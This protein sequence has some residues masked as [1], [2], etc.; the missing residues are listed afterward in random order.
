MMAAYIK[1]LDHNHL[2]MDGF[3][4]SELRAASLDIPEVDIVT[5]HHYPGSHKSFSELITENCA[6]AHG[7]KP[8]IIG[9]F[10]FVPTA[11]MA[12]TLRTIRES[13]AT[14]GLLW[15]LRFHNRDGGFYWH[16]EPGLGGNLYKAFHW[17]GSPLADAYDE[18]NLMALTRSNA[19]AIRGLPVPPVP[20]PA[21]P[22]LLPITDAAAISWQ[23]S[24]GASSYRI[25]RAAHKSGPWTVIDDL[26]DESAT[27]YRPEFA[28]ET[29]PRGQW[30]YRVTARNPSGLSTPSNV[31]GPVKVRAN[32]LVDELANF[33][34]IQSRTG[35][36]KIADRDG[37]QAKEDAQR[38]AGVAGSQLIYHLPARIQSFRVYALYPHDVAAVEFSVSTDG[39]TYQPVPVAHENYFQGVG[40]YG[41]WKPV[42][43]HAEAVSGGTYLKI[44]LK[45]ETQIGRVEITHDLPP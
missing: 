35:L 26:V 30:Y 36:W 45:G 37:R 18:V 25:E 17:P 11:D 33:S 12:T 2:V 31:V 8:Y 39:Q 13:D 15:S 16:S 23:G 43:F 42:R 7:R 1:S 44:E 21:A 14:G 34:K 9:E 28:D 41:Y 27:Q 3:G 20:V 22:N 40:D 4:T 24:V 29:V 38:A 19:F 6:Q 32:T 5:T 10:G